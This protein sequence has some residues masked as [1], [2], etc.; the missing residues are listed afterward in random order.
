[1]MFFMNKIMIKLWTQTFH[2]YEGKSKS[3]IPQKYFQM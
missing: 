2:T 3:A 1:M